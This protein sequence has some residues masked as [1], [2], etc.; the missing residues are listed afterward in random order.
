MAYVRWVNYMVSYISIKLSEQNRKGLCQP[1]HV[2]KYFSGIKRNKLSVH[3]ATWMD[4]KCSLE[5][6][7]ARPKRLHAGIPFIQYSGKGQTT[8]R[9]HISGLPGAA[10]GTGI[11]QGYR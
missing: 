10:G 6:K 8:G 2:T 11:Y 3:T 9:E 4:L 7:E 5:V 1:T